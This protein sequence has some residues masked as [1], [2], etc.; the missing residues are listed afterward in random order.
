[1]F[2]AVRETWMRRAGVIV[3]FLVLTVEFLGPSLVM[4]DDGVVAF[5]VVSEDPKD[6]ARVPAR[7]A[8]DGTVSQMRLLASEQILSNLIWK[9]LEICHALKLEG[10]KSQDGFHVLSVRAIDAAM[11]PMV[12]Q[13]FAG[14]CLL[15]KALEIAP[16]VD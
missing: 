6:T 13:G 16:F 4:A 10:H 7:I 2:N 1:M 15:R 8:I 11:L 14:D 5:A 3:C 12:L 9:K